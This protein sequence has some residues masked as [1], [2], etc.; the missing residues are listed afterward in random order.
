LLRDGAIGFWNSFRP[1]L[2]NCEKE[3]FFYLFSFLT[4]KK[5]IAAGL[6]ERV[7]KTAF[8]KALVFNSDHSNMP[9]P[10]DETFAI[11]RK[12]LGVLKHLQR[13]FISL[14]CKPHNQQVLIVNRTPELFV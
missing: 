14:R 10:G 1:S 12:K 8:D 7:A 4:L 11:V 5:Q 6:R 3:V 2:T 9:P 13:V